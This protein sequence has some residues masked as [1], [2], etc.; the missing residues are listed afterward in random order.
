[1]TAGLE[2]SREK[3]GRLLGVPEGM[4][5]LS[6]RIRGDAVRVITGPA[7]QEASLRLDGQPRELSHGTLR[8]Y[9][10]G[11]RCELCTPL[12]RTKRNRQ[13]ARANAATLETATNHY[14][15]WTGPEMEIAAREDLTA[16]EAAVMLGRSMKSVKGMRVKL[17]E[18]PRYRD[19]AGVSGGPPRVLGSLPGAHRVRRAACYAELAAS[20]TAISHGR[21]VTWPIASARSSP[22]SSLWSADASMYS[23]ALS[24]SCPSFLIARFLLTRIQLSLL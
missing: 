8:C 1:M 24:I 3:L 11:C 4:K 21:S 13:A 7:I 10:A 14:K 9:Q 23:L 16:R 18:D 15:Q 5:V 6:V 20:E 22:V 17:R 19:T 12:N 2:M